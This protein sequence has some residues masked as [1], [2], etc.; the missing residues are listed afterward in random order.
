MVIALVADGRGSGDR[1]GDDLALHLQALHPRVDEAFAELVE[2]EEAEQQRDEAAEVEHDDA[3]GERRRK[4]DCDRLL[5]R[6]HAPPEPP[7]ETAPE[8][9]LAGGFEGLFE[10]LLR[11]DAHSD[12][13]VHSLKR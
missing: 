8:V 9:A 2:I 13:R 6:A 1:G 10:L 4:A 11:F 7:D 5:K 3:A 12:R